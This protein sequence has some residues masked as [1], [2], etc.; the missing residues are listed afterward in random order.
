MKSP[1]TVAALDDAMRKRGKPRGVII[2]SDRG[3][4]FRFRTFQAALRAYCVK[5]SIGRA[6]AAGD[7]AVMGSF[8][9]LL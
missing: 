7:N 4:R 6:G 1:L 5:G 2:H 9:A 3:W 8:F